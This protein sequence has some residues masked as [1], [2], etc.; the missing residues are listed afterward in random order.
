MTLIC[1]IVLSNVLNGRGI[2]QMSLVVTFHLMKGLPKSI[3]GKH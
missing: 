3:K 2:M 1:I